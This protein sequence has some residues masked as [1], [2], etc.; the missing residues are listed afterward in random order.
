MYANPNRSHL[1]TAIIANDTITVFLQ[2]DSL[3][4]LWL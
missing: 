3:R 1:P 4:E 2:L